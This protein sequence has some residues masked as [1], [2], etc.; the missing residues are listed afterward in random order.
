MIFSRHARAIILTFLFF[1]VLNAQN[2]NSIVLEEVLSIGG[3]D[4]EL[5]YQWAGIC[6]D[7]E[8]NIYVTDMHDC[9]VIKFDSTGLFIDK[10]G[11][12][13]QGP[14]EF[15]KP[16]II[17]YHNDHLYVSELYNPG[18]SVFDKNLNFK[19]KIPYRHFI[20]D[21]YILENY[22]LMIPKTAG[23]ATKEK[24]DHFKIYDLVRNDTATI[25]IQTP[26]RKQDLIYINFTVDSQ[27][28]YSIYNTLDLISKIDLKGNTVWERSIY[29]NI[30]PSISSSSGFRISTDHT[31]KDIA[32]DQHGNIF[33]LSADYSKNKSRDIYVLENETGRH[34]TTVTLPERSHT[35]YICERNYLYS[36]AAMGAA[37]KKYAIIYK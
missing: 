8:N 28:I 25:P 12:Q 30:K 3:E 34:I 36:R 26:S 5:I 11:Q 20:S 35:I 29:K 4:S 10:T 14:G 23:H 24:Y 18:V 19:F 27:Y 9:T 22:K 21:F 17:K 1:S 31:F 2:F 6:V 16:V 32:L 13:G 7:D 15:I 37:L 33:V